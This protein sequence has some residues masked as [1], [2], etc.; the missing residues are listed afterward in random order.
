[1]NE[2]KEP[3][4]KE[5]FEERIDDIR[6]DRVDNLTRSARTLIVWMTEQRYTVAE[7]LVIIE[8]VHAS[9]LGSYML[10]IAQAE[11]DGVGKRVV[12]DDSRVIDLSTN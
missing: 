6:R 4:Q 8:L 11:I 12:P 9:V 10:N 3:E 1:M 5:Q 2:K 7:Q